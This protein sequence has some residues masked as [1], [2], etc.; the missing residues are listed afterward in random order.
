MD[1]KPLYFIRYVN[2]LGYNMLDQLLRISGKSSA[3]E[4]V[5]HCHDP[6]N[7]SIQ[8]AWQRVLGV[9]KNWVADDFQE[10]LSNFSVTHYLGSCWLKIFYVCIYIYIFR[11][12]AIFV[13]PHSLKFR[14]YDRFCFKKECLTFQMSFCFWL[15]PLS[16]YIVA[17]THFDLCE[18]D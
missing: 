9:A 11:N 13:V 4:L 16:Q 15:L 2:L 5:A 14:V 10:I 17:I 1:P 3:I 6:I 7:A 8:T 12:R 18:N